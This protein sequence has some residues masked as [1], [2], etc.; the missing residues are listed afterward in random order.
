MELTV[1]HNQNAHCFTI[2]IEN[3]NALLE[4]QVLQDGTLD[5]CHTFVP[6]SLRG[7]GVAAMLMKAACAFAR[8]TGAKILPTCSYADT[9]LKRN[10]KEFGDL[11]DQ[12][13]SCNPSCRIEK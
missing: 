10:A 3:E 8:T 2:E 7:K 11:L 9:Y 6:S 12:S 4:Y 5:F 13:R 1:T